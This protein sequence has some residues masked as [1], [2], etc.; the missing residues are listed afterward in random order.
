MLIEIIRF[1]IVLAGAVSGDYASTYIDLPKGLGVTGRSEIILF[2]LFGALF[3]YLIG[4]IAG[5]RLQKSL[6]WAERA[7]QKVPLPELLAGVVGLVLGLLVAFLVSL[8]LG[9]LGQAWQMPRLFAVVLLYVILGAS[10]VRLATRRWQDVG[11]PGGHQAGLSGWLAGEQTPSGTAI[12]KLLDTNILIDGRI[13]DVCRSGFIEGELVV[14]RFVLA[15][16]QAIADS[17][18]DLRRSRGRRG[19][20]VL[21]ALQEEAAVR[22]TLTDRDFPEERQVDAKL[23]RLAK[24]MGAAI[25][26][27]DYNLNKVA[28]VEGVKILNLNELT[29]AVKSILAA[30]EELVTKLHKAGKE[31]GQAVGYLEDG[32]MVVVDGG[33]ALLGKTVVSEVTGVLQTPAGRMVFAKL[34]AEV[35]SV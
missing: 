10:G 21:H 25:L 24:E 16:L 35:P 31:S 11:R 23:V 19:L 30:G 28:K 9:I 1:I 12:A 13:V 26:T 33:F 20:D 2:M 14:P 27:N 7:L 32:T 3:G 22:V 29:N 6:L 4:G 34:K 18:D 5:R 17:E 8:P 15:E